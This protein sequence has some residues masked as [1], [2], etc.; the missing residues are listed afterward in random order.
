LK[1]NLFTIGEIS[2]I[3]GITKKALRFYERIGLLMPCR[4]NPENGYRYYSLEQFVVMDIIKGMRTLDISPLVIKSVMEK[5]NTADLLRFLE[6]EKAKAAGRIEELHKIVETIGGVQDSIR[7]SLSSIMQSGVYVKRIPERLI[8]TLP[9][10]GITDG[11]D[12]VMAYAKF[13][14]LIAILELVNAYET[15]ILFK[16]DGEG[17]VPSLIFNVVRPRSG[18]DRSATS[19]IPAGEYLCICYTEKTAAKKSEEINRYCAAKRI[20]PSL[21]VQ[22]ELLNDIFSSNSPAVELQLLVHSN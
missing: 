18:A 8:V 22:S 6:E 2:R 15:G 14:H 11:G 16:N 19:V 3:K 17:F 13:D 9:Y 4:T 12:A 20:T 10:E 21:V 1:E 5:R 7:G